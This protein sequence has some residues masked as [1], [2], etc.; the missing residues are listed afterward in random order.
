M[1][2]TPRTSRA[3]IRSTPSPAARTAHDL[4]NALGALRLRLDIVANDSTCVW[5]QGGNLQAM[6]RILAEAQAL[7]HRLQTPNG[8]SS[9]RRDR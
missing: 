3:R 8:V 6:T 9:R 5:A 1:S 4:G 2:N 7:V